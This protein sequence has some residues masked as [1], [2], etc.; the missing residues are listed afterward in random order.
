MKGS[1]S[2]SSSTFSR[3]CWN[4]YGRSNSKLSSAMLKILWKMKLSKRV[5]G[6][7]LWH[8]K[9]RK[10]KHNSL[11]KV[12]AKNW[13]SLPSIKLSKSSRH[14]YISIWKLWMIVIRQ[15]LSW[16][17]LTQVKKVIPSHF[18]ASKFKFFFS[19][20]EDISKVQSANLSF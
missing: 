18:R 20:G 13:D 1:F 3:I 15:N 12:Y 7:F 14:E 16:T 6:V 19:H 4:L 10:R 17:Q 5:R 8:N 11:Q 2:R 9:P